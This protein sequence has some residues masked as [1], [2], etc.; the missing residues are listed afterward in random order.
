MRADSFG[1]ELGFEG[2]SD[3]GGS[4]AVHGEGDRALEEL[5]LRLV[6][7]G[8]EREDPVRACPP[9]EVL[10]PTTYQPAQPTEQGPRRRGERNVEVERSLG[11]PQK[12]DRDQRHG[13]EAEDP[14]VEPSRP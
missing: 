1:V 3:H 7:V 10:D 5:V 14:S 12:G 4:G 6:G 2:R 13:S 8:F 9:G 11:D